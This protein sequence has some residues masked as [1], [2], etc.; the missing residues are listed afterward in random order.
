MKPKG[1]FRVVSW[2]IRSCLEQGLAA[3][4]AVIDSLEADVIGLQEVDRLTM[5]SGAIDQTAELAER[6]GFAHYRFFPAT[7]W[8]G[9]G[10]YGVALLSRYELL[11][12][13]L[14]QMPIDGPEAHPS[15]TEPRVLAAAQ[16][17][18][19]VHILNTHFGLTDSQR[20]R[21]AA[22]V[23]EQAPGLLP[24]ILMGDFNAT[25]L[26]PVLDPLRAQLNDAA[27]GLS[28][29]ERISFPLPAPGIAIDH[30]FVSPD[31]RVLAA[32]VETA[33]QGASDHWPLVVDLSGPGLS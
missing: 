9:G 10:D 25:P 11:D 30:V 21:Q 27:A 24:T 31:L 19:G 14:M 4:A 28:P 1:S 18:G 12:P 16:L 32:R 33:A 15:A 13:Q 8:E 22:F 26:D 3:V 17:E 5:R 6:C 20:R 2:N 7:P 23:A 29:A